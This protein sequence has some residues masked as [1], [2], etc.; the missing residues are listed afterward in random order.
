MRIDSRKRR[1]T[2]FRVTALPT[3]LDVMK[4]HRLS[5]SWF[6]LT[7]S[8][9]VCVDFIEDADLVADADH[10]LPCANT[11]AKSRCFFIFS[12]WFNP[13][14]AALLR[15]RLLLW[16][17]LCCGNGCATAK[18]FIDSCLSPPAW[19]ARDSRALTERIKQAAQAQTVSCVRCFS[20]RFLSI[21][22]PARVDMRAR[23]PCLRSRRRTLG[24]YVLLGIQ[25]YPSILNLILL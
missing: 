11:A 18:E 13:H 25:K 7:I 10:A 5:V 1:R 23:N 14:A 24:W 12:V 2:R 9:T 3:R 6:G 19:G 22:R 15:Q 4:P 17:R 21:R 16:Q 20:R 8:L